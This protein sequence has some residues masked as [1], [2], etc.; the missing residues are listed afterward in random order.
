MNELYLACI[1]FLAFVQGTITGAYIGPTFV[2]DEI[3]GLEL[4][5]PMTDFHD[6]EIEQWDCDKISPYDFLSDPP[7]PFDDEEN[8]EA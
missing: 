5:C 4:E 1:Y 8:V 6:S 7:N 3:S 2:D